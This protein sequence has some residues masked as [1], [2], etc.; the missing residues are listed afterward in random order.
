MT[1]ESIYFIS[2]IVSA[3]AIAASLIFVGLQLRQSDKTQRAVMHQSRAD[4]LLSM[5]NINLQPQV[6]ASMQ[7]AFRMPEELTPG[8]LATL[9]VVTHYMVTH[10]DDVK[11]QHEAGFLD[12]VSARQNRVALRGFFSSLGV[13]ALWQS[14]GK[15]RFDAQ[16]AAQVDRELIDGVPLVM[17]GS[18]STD[19]FVKT[20]ETLKSST[21]IK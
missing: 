15:Q 18:V 8:D 16:L 14:G 9:S 10:Y 3:V 5:A 2:Q 11:W 6:A 20:L 4:R 12:G 21:L 19:Q 7:K 13:R 17:P 1:L